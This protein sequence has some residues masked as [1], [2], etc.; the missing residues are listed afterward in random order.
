MQLG[1]DRIGSKYCGILRIHERRLGDRRAGV[2]QRRGGGRVNVGVTHRDHIGNRGRSKSM[3]LA[4]TGAIRCRHL[5]D[6]GIQWL[7]V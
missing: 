3:T 4:A 6:V 2:I 1:L 7:P 5:S